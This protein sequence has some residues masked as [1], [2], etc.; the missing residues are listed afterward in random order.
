MADAD[1]GARAEADCDRG[2]DFVTVGDLFAD[3]PL[4]SVIWLDCPPARLRDLA[5]LLSNGDP[6][7]PE[8]GRHMLVL[9][10]PPPSEGGRILGPATLEP[11]E[12]DDPKALA[13]AQAYVHAIGLAAVSAA[14]ARD[15]GIP[16]TVYAIRVQPVGAKFPSTYQYVSEQSDVSAGERG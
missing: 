6:P 11:S 12:E 9:T 8:A 2:A 10:F 13:Y 1:A 14:C 15:A 7:E 16:A 5:V 4:E 3:G